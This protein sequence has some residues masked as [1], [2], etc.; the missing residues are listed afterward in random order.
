MIWNI[1][2]IDA[3]RN[4]GL[5]PAQTSLDQLQ[6]WKEPIRET[7]GE[8]GRQTRGKRVELAGCR[9]IKE[10][11]YLIFCCMKLTD[12]R[13]FV[14]TRTQSTARCTSRKPV[15]QRIC[16]CSAPPQLSCAQ[17][18]RTAPGMKSGSTRCLTTRG[19][20]TRMQAEQSC[21]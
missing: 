3:R 17:C 2:K 19:A 10:D 8:V 7:L 16:L 20:Q 1:G 13:P 21:I 14:V 12:S 18:M 15:N 6:T 11:T 5:R 4:A 9:R